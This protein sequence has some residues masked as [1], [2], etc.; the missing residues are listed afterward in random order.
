MGPG[1]TGYKKRASRDQLREKV[2]NWRIFKNI[3][4]ELTLRAT[5]TV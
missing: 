2:T 4:M 3:R 1:A 5:S